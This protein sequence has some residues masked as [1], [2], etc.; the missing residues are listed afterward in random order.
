MFERFAVE[1]RN[2]VVRSVE[3]AGRRGDRRLGTE[4]LLLAA[5]HDDGIASAL[6]VDAAAA[7]AAADAADREALSEIG[8]DVAAYGPLVHAVGTPRPRLTAGGKVVMKRTLEYAVVER[9]RRIELRHLVLALLERPE[10]DPAAALLS[11]LGID[12]ARARSALQP[13]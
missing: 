12:P 9:S 1:A 2:T 7:E 6:G 4:H 5:L 10:P 13:R 11:R 8:V 3:V